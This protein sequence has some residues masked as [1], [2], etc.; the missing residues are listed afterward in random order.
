MLNRRGGVANEWV[1]PE[2]VSSLTASAENMAK[3][4]S[5][6][7]PAA[8]D[9]ASAVT[10]AALLDLKSSKKPVFLIVKIFVNYMYLYNINQGIEEN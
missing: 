10:P 2:K 9:L 6:P 8:L 3:T 1:S 4:S 5:S 7:F